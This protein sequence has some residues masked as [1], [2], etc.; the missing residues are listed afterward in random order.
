MSRRLERIFN[1]RDKG[2]SYG[3]IKDE[4]SSDKAR[5]QEAKQK[6]TDAE[7]QIA[8]L[9]SQQTYVAGVV[10]PPDSTQTMYIKD[11]QVFLDPDSFLARFSTSLKIP[12]SSVWVEVKLSQKRVHDYIQTMK[13][14]HK[15]NSSDL[16]YWLCQNKQ[17]VLFQNSDSAVLQYFE[18]KLWDLN[19]YWEMSKDF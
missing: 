1:L 11:I 19:Y 14:R 18:T 5:S 9:L 10:R 7:I 2:L 8:K 17:I 13:S 16:Q 15:F 3:Q 4:L 12:D 6:A